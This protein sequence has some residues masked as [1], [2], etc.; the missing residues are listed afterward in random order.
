M[1]A[2][3]CIDKENLF[4]RADVTVIGPDRSVSGQDS[5]AVSGALFVHRPV[6]SA[7]IIMN[8]ES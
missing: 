6:G 2:W 1:Q 4:A 3:Y 8:P 5:T 7:A